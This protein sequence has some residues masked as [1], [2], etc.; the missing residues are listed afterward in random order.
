MVSLLQMVDQRMGP[1][2]LICVNGCVK[3]LVICIKL[4]GM[5]PELDFGGPSDL[6]YCF[7]V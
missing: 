5:D 3:I 1:K 7:F 2:C 4:S 6:F